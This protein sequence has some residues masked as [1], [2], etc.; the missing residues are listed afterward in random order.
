MSKYKRPLIPRRRL[1]EWL[2][3]TISFGNRYK[4]VTSCL[5]ENNLYSVCVEARCPNRAEC[6][7]AGT[8]TFLIMGNCCTR[9]CGFC[10][11]HHGKPLMLDPEEPQKVASAAGDLNLRH[12]VITSVTRDDL[13]DGGAAHFAETVRQCRTRVP[14]STIELLVPD[15]RGKQEALDT[16]VTCRPDILSHNLETVPRLYTKIR[17]QADYRHSLNLLSYAHKKNVPAK[18]GFMV[19]LGETD[20]EVI[21]VLRDLYAAGCRMVTIGQYLQP[22]KEQVPVH[23]YIT[24]EQ[25]SSYEK[26]GR[27]IGLRSVFTGPFVRS[28]YHSQEVFNNCTMTG[29]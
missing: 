11:V 27:T 10:G 19:G 28:S 3:K 29:T 15:F 18:S 12:I 26:S 25:F 13:P 4:S 24:P 8:A 23:C 17:P 22:S 2:K 9:N 14:K 1:P 21:A 16:V 7:S 5:A 6:F 20:E